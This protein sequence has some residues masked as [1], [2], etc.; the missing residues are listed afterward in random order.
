MSIPEELRYSE[1]HEWVR[2]EKDIA[3][4]GI[5]HYAQDQLGDIVFVDLPSTGK[6]LEVMEVFGTVEAVKT[7]S[8]LYCPVSGIIIEV[9]S[10]LESRPES[11]NQDPYGEGWMIR[12]K[13]T[14]PSDFENLLTA[15]GYK[16][17]IGE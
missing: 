15:S 5:T 3:T 1:E 8:D 10:A 16:T 17:L 6:T 4:I 7:V 12:V 14:T 9:N 2:L 13:M 11:V